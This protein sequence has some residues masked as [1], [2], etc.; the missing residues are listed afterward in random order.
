[1][2]DYA[3]RYPNSVS[4]GDALTGLLDSA[5]GTGL[6]P[7]IEASAL[8]PYLRGEAFVDELRRV[9]GWKLV[10]AAYARPPASTEQILHPEKY[11]RVEQPDAV[12]L[13]VGLPAPWRQVATGTVGEFDTGQLLERNGID[14][15]TAQDA[16][17]GWGGGAYELWRQGA[18]P[19]PACQAPCAKRDAVVI[20]WRWDSAK[21]AREFGQALRT[22]VKRMRGGASAIVAGDRSTVL[23]LAP[24]AAQASALAAN[25]LAGG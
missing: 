17:A 25:S 14:P 3:R 21:D 8:F 1:M 23:A 13:K 15:G 9:G 10:N 18:L 19:D 5:G 12:K 4:L 11:L 7:Y 20:A 2:T 24:T 6:P 22:A 16:A